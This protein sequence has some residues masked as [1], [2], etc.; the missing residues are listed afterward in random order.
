MPSAKVADGSCSSLPS[1]QKC[2]S[3]NGCLNLEKTEEERQKELEVYKELKRRKNE[4]EEKLLAKLE[5]LREV[6]IKEAEITGELPKE[7]YKTLMPGE[8]E[9]KVK[10]RVGTAFTF[11]EEVF[12]KPND[13]VA[14]LE[15]DVELHR[16]IVAAAERLAKDKTTN[17]SVRK[18]RQ[19]DLI[20][21]TQKLRGLELGL[22]KL[23]L[24]ASKPDISSS[25]DGSNGGCQYENIGYK[26]C[27]SYKSTYRQTNFPT[28]NVS[29][30]NSFAISKT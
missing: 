11:S 24:S 25:V 20:A 29:L 18:K 19:K 2:T 28:L 17:K 6:C 13:K 15:T 12:K 14:M 10:R 27:A 21:A 5:E 23:R 22:S 26:S 16:K 4:L 8:V 1:L 7:I 3:L 9:P 30:S